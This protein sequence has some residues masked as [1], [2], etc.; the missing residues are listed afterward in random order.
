VARQKW[1]VDERIKAEK[2]Q[3]EEY[4]RRLK[5][6]V[7]NE[8]KSIVSKQKQSFSDIRLSQESGSQK[9]RLSQIE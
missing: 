7:N 1:L 3:Q 8:I 4:E 5:M 2:R 9:S 6:R